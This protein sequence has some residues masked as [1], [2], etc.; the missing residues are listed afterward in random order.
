MGGKEYRVICT[1]G[2]HSLEFTKGKQNFL[3]FYEYIVVVRDT[4][5][6]HACT[7]VRTCSLLVAQLSNLCSGTGK[8]PL[9]VSW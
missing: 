6:V 5:R 7:H 8:F 3:S 2:Y 4:V 1:V 9:Y